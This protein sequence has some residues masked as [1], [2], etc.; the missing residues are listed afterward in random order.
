MPWPSTRE[1]GNAILDAIVICAR[2]IGL[3]AEAL[4]VLCLL[5]LAAL[6]IAG[7][8]FLLNKMQVK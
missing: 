5:C 1:S 6:A 7:T 2:V 3:T 8:I 4:A